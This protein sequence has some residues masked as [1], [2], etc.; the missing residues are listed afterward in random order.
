ME[1]A[2]VQATREQLSTIGIDRDITGQTGEVI[3]YYSTGYVQIELPYGRKSR[4]FISNFDLPK[5]WLEITE[6]E[7]E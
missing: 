2:K 3:R 5:E 1:I 7:D 6:V 4:G